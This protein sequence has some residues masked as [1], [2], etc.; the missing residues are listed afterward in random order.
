MISREISTKILELSTAF[1]VISILGP[2]Q[3]G[4]TTL[5]RHLFPEKDYANLE[6]PDTRLF[7]VT[8]P[9]AFLANHPKG[10]VID[11]AQRVPELFSYIQTQVDAVRNPGQIILTGS[12]HF[13]LHERISQTL[14]GRVAMF[15]LLPF[16][17]DELFQHFSHRETFQTYMYQGFYPP[18]YAQPVS[19]P[20]WYSN[21][22]LTY[23]ERDV[24]QIKNITDLNTFTT[25][26]KLCAGRIGQLLN[27][28]S[29]AN[30]LGIA[31]NTIRSWLSV[32]E[33]S[34]IVFQLPPYYK[35]FNKRLVKMRKLYFYDTGLASY[36]LGIRDLS[37]LDTHFLRGELFENL[38]ISEIVK[39]FHNRGEIPGFYFWRDRSSREVDFLIE[40]GT[41]LKAIE[42][43]IAQTIG[44]DFFKG[45]TYWQ[46]IS[47][48]P[49]GD[50]GIIY[51]GDQRQK[52]SQ[53]EIIPWFEVP[54]W[55][56]EVY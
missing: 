40:Y 28:T 23:V 21:Y 9:R 54:K 37:Q 2:R 16:S 10:L 18:L 1:P 31:V 14:A 49:A 33:A 17:L 13:L 48:S 41:G 45:L 38:M 35:N 44:N 11:E 50:C 4:K 56:K 39:F 3:S 51:G 34:F 8:D 43:K 29:L 36:L 5:V 32:L 25:F 46:Q 53:G 26:L 7:A 30:E 20:N 52:R 15:Q 55:L 24:R 22:I 19:P 12:Q 42:I 6:E 47:G 27:L